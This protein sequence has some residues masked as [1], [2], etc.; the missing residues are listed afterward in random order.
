MHALM[1]THMHA[2]PMTIACSMLMHTMSM[3]AH[4]SIVIMTYPVLT[5]VVQYLL[6]LG[7]ERTTCAHCIPPSFSRAPSASRGS[8]RAREAISAGVER[9]SHCTTCDL[10]ILLNENNWFILPCTRI[11]VNCTVRFIGRFRCA[12]LSACVAL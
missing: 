11:S 4:R 2:W 6:D 10:G 3:H 1:C 7:V 5:R 8:S 9:K 12:V